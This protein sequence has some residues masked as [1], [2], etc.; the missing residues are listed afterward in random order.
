MKPQITTRDNLQIQL[1]GGIGALQS[2][3]DRK[4]LQEIFI[5]LIK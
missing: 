2:R 5:I 1:K 4:P 3:N